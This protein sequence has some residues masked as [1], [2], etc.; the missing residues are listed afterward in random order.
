[1]NLTEREK[2]L[3]VGALSDVKWYWQ[4]A[5]KR[6]Q[7]KGFPKDAEDYLKNASELQDLLEKV[8]AE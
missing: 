4:L 3:I 5:A 6:N 8:K 2:E 7:E 1:M